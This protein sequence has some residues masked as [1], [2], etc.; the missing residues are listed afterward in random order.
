LKD[1]RNLNAT[2]G[3]K[4]VLVTKG[5]AGLGNR[6]LS[7]LGSIM[8]CRMTNRK[9]CVDWSDHFYS[10]D[11]ENV[12]PSFFACKVQQIDISQVS[13][14]DIYPPIWHGNLYKFV[15]ELIRTY[16]PKY[17]DAE[18]IV[19]SKYS[20]LIDEPNLKHKTLVRWSYF[21]DFSRIFKQL[22]HHFY[23]EKRRLDA[24]RRTLAENITLVEP[25]SSELTKLGANLL[26]RET[27]GVHIRLTDLHGPYPLLLSKLRKL[28]FEKKHATI[29][30]ATDNR[31]VELEI[32]KMFPGRVKKLDKLMP[33]D[34]TPI[35]SKKK[36]RSK[37]ALKEAL[38][39][40]Y[41]LSF[42]N[43]LI[44]SST[45]S[46]GLCSALLSQAPKGNIF[47]CLSP[48]RQ[49]KNTMKTMIINVAPAVYRRF[50]AK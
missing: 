10:E 5:K 4:E 20:I 26:E 2:N 21:D 19:Y 44:F 7:L 14:E 35:F 28:A 1:S 6:L 16:D 41:L 39:D 15:D 18:M 33:N 40:M 49:F 31:K 45:S 37:Q 8:Y 22:G 43:Y 48:K 27:I 46:F 36:F 3:K 30:L 17:S 29:F 38:L 13:D 11:G 34:G 23:S 24:L 12:F 9:L 42:C 32:E 47:D 50:V 25:F